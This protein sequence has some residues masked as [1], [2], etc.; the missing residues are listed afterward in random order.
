[1]AYDVFTVFAVEIRCLMSNILFEYKAD[2][3]EIFPMP[4]EAQHPPIDN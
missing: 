1:M 2:R 4:H 3:G